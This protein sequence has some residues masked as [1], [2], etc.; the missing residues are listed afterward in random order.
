MNA[1][2]D[3]SVLGTATRMTRSAEWFSLLQRSGC[4]QD[5]DTFDDETKIR[6]SR[7]RKLQRHFGEH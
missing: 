3:L 4:W 6:I 2:V 7:L 5:L 1:R